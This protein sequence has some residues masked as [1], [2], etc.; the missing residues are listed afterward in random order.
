LRESS[1]TEQYPLAQK[2]K[3]GSPIHLPFETFQLIDF[4]FGLP[5]AFW[6]TECRFH[7]STIPLNAQGKLPQFPYWAGLSAL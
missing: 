2:S 1:P 5:I 6:S 3:R 7:S 4:A